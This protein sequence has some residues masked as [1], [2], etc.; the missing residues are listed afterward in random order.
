MK[1]TFKFCWYDFWIGI[2]Y[3]RTFN[4]LYICPLPMCLIRIELPEKDN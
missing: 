2:Y 3:N 4:V 1:V